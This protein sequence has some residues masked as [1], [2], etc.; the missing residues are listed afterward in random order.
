MQNNAK[1]KRKKIIYI[2]VIQIVDLLFQ[3]AEISSLKKYAFQKQQLCIS[4]ENI[5][6]K[7]IS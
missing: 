3:I 1:K 5:L 6:I 2:K 7:Y 4:Q